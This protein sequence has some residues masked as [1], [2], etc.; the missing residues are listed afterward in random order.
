MIKQIVQL[1]GAIC[2][3]PFLLLRNLCRTVLQDCRDGYQEFKDWYKDFLLESQHPKE[4]DRLSDSQ[5]LV[6]SL[7]NEQKA[8]EMEELLRRY[9]HKQ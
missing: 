4:E 8:A 1:I 6:R 5:K 7:F 9:Q 2:S 3:I